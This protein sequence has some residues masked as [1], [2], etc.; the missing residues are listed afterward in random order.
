M[1]VPLHL[2]LLALE[3]D[4]DSVCGFSIVS[5]R[6]GL[7]ESHYTQL[8]SAVRTA[9]RGKGVYAGLTRLLVETLPDH[10]QLLNVTHAENHAMQRAYL[11]TGRLHY[12]DTLVLRRVFDN[13]AQSG[14]V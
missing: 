9:H 4:S 8:L 10:A 5:E 7:A 2:I 1:I 6:L 14:P 13:A 3:A 12:A 11:N